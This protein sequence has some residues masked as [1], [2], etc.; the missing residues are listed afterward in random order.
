[1]EVYVKMVWLNISAI[2]QKLRK[3]SCHGGDPQCTVQLL[4]CIDHPCQN[5]ATCLPWWMERHI[6]ILVFVHLGFYGDVCSTP[7]T[8]SF[9]SPKFS[10]WSSTTWAQ[11]ERHRRTGT[12]PG[13]P[14][15]LPPPHCLICLLFFRGNAEFFLSLEIVGGWAACQGVSKEGGSLEQNY[16]R[17]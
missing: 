15:T 14:P 7:T 4:G 6:D 10:Y 5:D 8:F 9:S 17:L 16:Q 1:M 13:G 3:V 2:V 11:K 12:P